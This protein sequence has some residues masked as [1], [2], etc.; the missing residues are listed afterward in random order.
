MIW[1]PIAFW[2]SET[3]VSFYD[4][5]FEFSVKVPVPAP[6]HLYSLCGHH[7]EVAL[8]L[9]PYNKYLRYPSGI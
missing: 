7:L 4:T 9:F 3:S 8:E 1:G 6:L 5:F 2:T